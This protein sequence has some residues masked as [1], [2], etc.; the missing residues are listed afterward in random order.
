MSNW[1]DVKDRLPERGHRVIVQDKNYG[2]QI[3]WVTNTEKWV[4][5]YQI[6][7]KGEVTHW[8]SLPEPPQTTEP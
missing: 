7:T 1:I 6:P 2:V 4:L 3:G 5:A 8:M